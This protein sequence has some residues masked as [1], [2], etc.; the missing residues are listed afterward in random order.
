MRNGYLEEKA[1]GTRFENDL[2]SQK[3]SSG[4]SLVENSGLSAFSLQFY[5]G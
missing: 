2:T 1:I 3:L 5:K 4:I